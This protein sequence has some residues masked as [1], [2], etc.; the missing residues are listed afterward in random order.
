MGLRIKCQSKFLRNGLQK[1][2][3]LFSGLHFLQQDHILVSA[4]SSDHAP[5]SHQFLHDLSHS[6]DDLVTKDMTIGIIDMFE[7]ININDHQPA[8]LTILPIQ[9]FDGIFRPCPFIQQTGSGIPGCRSQIV[10]FLLPVPVRGYDTSHHITFFRDPGA[11]DPPYSLVL[12]LTDEFHL[13]EIISI[14]QMRTESPKLPF[15]YGN[16]TALM[17]LLHIPDQRI[18]RPFKLVHGPLVDIF[19][20][21]NTVLFDQIFKKVNIFQCHKMTVLQNALLQS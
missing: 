8:D 21:R 14:A 10:S 20:D 7:I 16:I 12:L 17:C 13:K 2:L 9:L 3:Q 1:C 19:I 5:L 11:F 4:E 18:H 15:Q 6:A